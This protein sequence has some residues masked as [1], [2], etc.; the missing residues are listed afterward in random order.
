MNC[1]IL[2]FLILMS[3][4]SLMSHSHAEAK[5][6]SLT[7][8][9]RMIIYEIQLRDF[10]GTPGKALGDGTAAK[11]MQSVPALK[12]YGGTP[13][14]YL[15]HLGID[16]ILL[17]PDEAYG[18]SDD[19]RTLIKAAHERDIEVILALNGD[20]SYD[21]VEHRITDFDADGLS[22]DTD[23]S[24]VR[25]LY[26][27]LSAN[28]P[29][30]YFIN[31][32][33]TA[34]DSEGIF[35]TTNLNEAA[36]LYAGG[37]L[38]NASLDPLCD[39]SS[40]CAVSYVESYDTERVAYRAKTDGVQGVKGNDTSS[41]TNRMRRLGSLAAQMLMSPGPHLIRQ[42]EEL[43]ADQISLNADG[44]PNQA[45]KTVVWNNINNALYRTLHDTYSSLC[46]IRRQYPGLFDGTASCRASLSL[47]T[48][49]Y[50]SLSDNTLEL[51]LVVNP[52]VS[53]TA[54]ITPADAVTGSP[55]D[56]S[57]PGYRLLASS[58]DVTPSVTPAG[59]SLPGGA[60]AVYMRELESAISGITPDAPVGPHF[61]LIDGVVHPYGHYSSM[62]IHTIAGAEISSGSRLIPGLYLVT[63]DGIT[64]KIVVR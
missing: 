53:G 15:H 22:I 31:R 23:D 4:S 17:T 32:S 27:R 24:T 13:L 49:R 60:F 21:A 36:A 61:D 20:I 1:R 63:I 18:T 39:S 48:E 40:Y 45:P 55:A 54:V 28:H 7:H 33:T 12:N 35:I 19:Y 59:V 52:A 43:G 11:M 9:S 5:N 57:A 6:P 26:D 47:A 37:Q 16:A 62:T 50:I 25:D 58:P 41:A 8:A 64:V 2:F 44:T 14:D 3:L 38:D 46:G 34:T 51:H 56:L 29:D 30:I 10:T 42:F